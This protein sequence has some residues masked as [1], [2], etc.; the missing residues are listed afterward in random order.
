MCLNRNISKTIYTKEAKPEKATITTKRWLL[1]EEVC[2]NK[3]APNAAILLSFEAYFLNRKQNKSDKQP[4]RKVRQ[5]LISDTVKSHELATVGRCS[6]RKSASKR[7]YSDCKSV[8]KK[9]KNWSVPKPKKAAAG[10]RELFTRESY[11]ALLQ[12]GYGYTPLIG[13]QASMKF[14]PNA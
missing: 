4:G 13:G 1:L 9:E 7:D 12:L 5:L 11:M 3:I 14:C 8:P 6:F 10:T 2:R